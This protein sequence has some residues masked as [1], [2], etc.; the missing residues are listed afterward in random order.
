MAKGRKHL[1][2]AAAWK[3]SE[4]NNWIALGIG[5]LVAVALFVGW[6]ILLLSGTMQNSIF[7]LLFAFLI[8]FVLGTFGNKVAKASRECRKVLMAHD[9]SKEDLKEYMR[10]QKSRP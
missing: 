3:R 1:E 7:V 8:A 6:N 4:R 5:I 9:L 2:E 10:A